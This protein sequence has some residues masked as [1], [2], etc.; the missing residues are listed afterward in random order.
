MHNKLKRIKIL[1]ILFSLTILLGCTTRFDVDPSEDDFISYHFGGGELGADFTEIR[2][3]GNGNITYLYKVPYEGEW[4]PKKVDKL[5]SISK[6]EVVTLFQTLIDR[7]LFDQKSKK[8]VGQD[9]PSTNVRALID[10]HSIN[11]SFPGIRVPQEISDLINKIHPEG[12]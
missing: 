6:N 12:I 2:I 5:Y 4:P 9:V 8:H 11:V 7:G 1:F 3:D 10:G